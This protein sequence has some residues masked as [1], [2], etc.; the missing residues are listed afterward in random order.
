MEL[1]KKE[2]KFRG[3]TLE[4]LKVLDVR[5]FSK[6]LTS[7]QRRA[8]LRQ[9][10]EVEKFLNRAKDKQS[11]NKAIRTHSRTL[12]VV[13]EM[14]GMK[15]MIYNGK[16]FVPVIIMEEMLGHRFGEFAPTRSKIKHAS[17]TTKG[18]RPKSKK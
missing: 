12:I 13:P 1:Q 5:E 17:S 7:K 11:K 18:S 2:F 10:Q 6:F 4:E 9:F 15:I 3:K 8:V 14:V 16:T